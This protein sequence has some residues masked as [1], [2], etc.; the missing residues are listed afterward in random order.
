MIFAFII[1]IENYQA[2]MIEI[3]F[4]GLVSLRT[5][6]HGIHESDKLVVTSKCELSGENYNNNN[7]N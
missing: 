2:K 1:D 6:S 4:K 5:S 7:N 3:D